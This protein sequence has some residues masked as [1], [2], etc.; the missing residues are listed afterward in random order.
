MAIDKR[1]YANG[2]TAW[3]VRVFQGRRVVDTRTFSTLREAK[4]FDASR[5][6]AIRNPDWV[7][8]SAGKIPF[9]LLAQEW[10]ETR[11]NMAVRTRD[12]D[13]DNYNRYLAPTFGARY[14]S[15]ISGGD[16]NQW[17]G[18]L[19]GR[20]VPPSSRRRALSVLR[21][22]L[23]YAVASRRIVSSPATLIKL[24][25]G[26][27]RR[28][29]RALSSDELA[30]LLGEIDIA[31]RPVVLA[32]ATMGLRFS[33][34]SALTCADVIQAIPRGYVVRVHRARTQ[35]KGGGA[36]VMG[37]TKGHRSRPVPVPNV[38]KQWVQERVQSAAKT[39]PLFQAPMGGHWTNTNFRNRTHWTSAVSRANLT[40]LRLHDLRHSAGSALLVASK[41]DLLAVSRILG[42]S[43]PT[44]TGAIYSHLLDGQIFDAMDGLTVP[45][46]SHNEGADQETLEV[47]RE[48]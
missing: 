19:A 27:T 22:I 46:L 43:S 4:A 45:G 14:I 26:G 48:N 37:D 41:G 40:G 12:T 31:Y 34:L 25:K 44:V 2:K 28:E 29:G 16:I 33:E 24:P 13:S 8:S 30:H 38:L 47:K 10:L 20:N 32:L 17:L 15:S 5:R 36:P 21:G 42:H 6:E 9:D 35:R 3:R 23:N 7:P 11:R 39:S 1:L 18:A